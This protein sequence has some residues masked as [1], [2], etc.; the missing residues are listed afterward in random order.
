MTY[1]AI[2][3][4]HTVRAIS[5]TDVDTATDV[6]RGTADPG[7]EVWVD[8][9]GAEDGE[10]VVATADGSGEW[11]ADFSAV[12]DITV[13]TN[14]GVQQKD[15][16]GNGTNCGFEVPFPPVP[17]PPGTSVETEGSGTQTSGTPTVY[18]HDPL[19]VTTTGRSGGTGTATLTTATATCRRSRWSRPRLPAARTRARSPRPTRTMEQR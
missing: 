19:T 13:G 8:V 4:T 15:E 10:G 2:T 3:R 1:G 18:W 6:V 11:A 17:I 16:G 14:V 9:S 5:I 12:Y 7:T